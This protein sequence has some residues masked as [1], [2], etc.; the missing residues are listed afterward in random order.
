MMVDLYA[1]TLR[2]HMP[3]APDGPLDHVVYSFRPIEASDVVGTSNGIRFVTEAAP[4]P[5]WRIV[6]PDGCELFESLGE[7]NLGF[8]PPSRSGISASVAYR[9]AIGLKFGFR[10]L[11]IAGE[12]ANGSAR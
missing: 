6:C 1:S 4:S 8:P 9:L 7:L 3:G 5:R 10:L 11:Q 12:V 2:R